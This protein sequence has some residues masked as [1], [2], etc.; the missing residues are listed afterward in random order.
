MRRL[1]VW[2]HDRLGRLLGD[3]LFDA[4]LDDCECFIAGM[5]EAKD[6]VGEWFT[7]PERD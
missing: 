2:V 1:L 6:T 4:H 7:P 3:E 5:E